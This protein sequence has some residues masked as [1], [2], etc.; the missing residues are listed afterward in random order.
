MTIPSRYNSVPTV[1]TAFITWILMVPAIKDRDG[2]T[3][4]VWRH[5]ITPLLLQ[6]CMVKLIIPCCFDIE[7]PAMAFLG[8][9]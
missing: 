6:P 2:R 1:L 9:L 8:Q 4:S 5:K 3:A 7:Q